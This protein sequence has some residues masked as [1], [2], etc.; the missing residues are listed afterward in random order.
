MMITVEGRALDRLLNKGGFFN[1]L[2]DLKV[3]G[4]SVRVIA[5]DL[6]VHPVSD[7]PLHIDFMRVRAGEKITVQVPVQFLNE[8]QSPGLKRGGMLN[9]VR[10]EVELFCD[11][12]SIPGSIAF[13][14]A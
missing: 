7:K 3:G 11:P 1:Q 10:H 14:L 13:D 12:A 2:W 4:Q 6:Q 5:Q 9:V 8:E